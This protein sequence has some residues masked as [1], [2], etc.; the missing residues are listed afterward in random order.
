[1]LIGLC[2]EYQVAIPT[3]N[4]GR[5]NAWSLLSQN[6]ADLQ[7]ELLC[8]PQVAGWSAYYQAPQYHEL[9]INS[10][11]YSERNFLT[12]TMVGTGNMMN[13]TNLRIDAVGFTSTLPS[14]QDPNLLIIDALSV[15]LRPPLADSDIAQ[16]KQTILLGGGA[17]DI[18][19]TNAWLNYEAA[20]TD[21]SA[22]NIV[23]TRLRALY[24]YLMDLPEYHLS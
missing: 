24:K 3:D 18:Y 16:I 9:W 23:D 20:P 1:M 6:A 2:R 8:I 21:M 15:L 4:A 5:Y 10:V 11:T 7:Q 22:F 19:W 13:G 12:D 14:P 17:N